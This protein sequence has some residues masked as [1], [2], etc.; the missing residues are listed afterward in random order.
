MPTIINYDQASV[1]NG[2]MLNTEKH[3]I[4]GAPVLIQIFD[5]CSLQRFP[6]ILE[7]YFKYANRYAFEF[8]DIDEGMEGFEECRIQD[9]QAIAIVRALKTAKEKDQN[10]FVHCFAG[11]ARSG[12]VVEYAVSLGFDDPNVY[13]HPNKYVLETLHRVESMV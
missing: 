8:L 13:R 5:I 9:D 4:I 3:N 2:Y 1:Y 11:V 7:P 10:V 12:A 6:V